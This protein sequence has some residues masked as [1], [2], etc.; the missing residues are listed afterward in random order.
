MHSYNDISG[1][2]V[3]L[4]SKATGQIKRIENLS[5]VLGALGD[6]LVTTW[7]GIIG[8]FS[9]LTAS[10]VLM[11]L[12]LN[13]LPG[14][15][16]VQSIIPI[17]L[18]VVG[19][20]LISL[21]ILLTNPVQGS[22][23]FVSIKFLIK[24]LTTLSDSANTRKVFKPFSFFNDSQTI[25]QQAYKGRK[26]Y[27][28]VFSIRGIVSPVTFNTDLENAA[29]ADSNLLKNIGRDTVL[30][31]AVNIKKTTV[32]KRMLPKNA[33]PAMIAKRDLQYSI[34]Q[35]SK[36]NQQIST[37]NIL[38]CQNIETLRGQT[39]HLRAAYNRGLVVGYKQLSG[40]EI[41]R[42]FNSIFG[43]GF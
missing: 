4:R 37:I 38:S 40:K 19:L 25:V 13:H 22:Q 34:T 3:N 36:N 11:F 15:V 2:K 27:M 6:F 31:T 42:S 18:I 21:N 8:M 17:L 16:L 29:G 10:A 20:V 12:L 28:T 23:L 35:D 43:E 1:N 32:K 33:S 30:T 5:T 24:K 7:G 39:E 41:K 26:R 14:P 9:F